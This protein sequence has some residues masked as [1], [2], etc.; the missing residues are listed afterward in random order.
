M[1]Q[2]AL[3]QWGS[4]NNSKYTP[5][6]KKDELIKDLKLASFSSMFSFC[7]N[8]SILPLTLLYI[9]SGL[10]AVCAGTLSFVS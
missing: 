3:Y 8:S 4:I 1:A 9:V 2:V 7:I 5:I 6:S 10:G